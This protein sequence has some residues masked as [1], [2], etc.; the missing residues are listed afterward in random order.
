MGSE[1]GPLDIIF[2][3]SGSYFANFFHS[4]FRLN[5]WRSRVYASFTFYYQSEASMPLS[6]VPRLSCMYASYSLYITVSLAASKVPSP[7]LHMS[8]LASL[9]G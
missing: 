3:E 6:L 1:T 9:N 4:L 7:A 5:S 2:P 8:C